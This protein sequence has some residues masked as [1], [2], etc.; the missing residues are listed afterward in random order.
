MGKRSGFSIGDAFEG[1]SEYVSEESPASLDEAFEEAA[2]AATAELGDRVLESD[3]EFDV[4]LI[5]Q[6]RPHNQNVR[7]YKVIL[8]PGP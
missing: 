6:T 2:K 7:T 8:T 1:R 3:V 4:R 5:I